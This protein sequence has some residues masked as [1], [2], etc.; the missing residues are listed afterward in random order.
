M[1]TGFAYGIF[2][3]ESKKQTNKEG[4]RMKLFL[5]RRKGTTYVDEY[6]SFIVREKT[7]H[8]AR[9]VAASCCADEGRDCWLD[10][11]KVSCHIL[12]HD[13]KPGLV[14]SSFNGG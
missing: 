4:Q 1:T 9:M 6:E 12:K 14:V 7:P 10:P 11:S 13:G 8:R 5:L 2:I 3:A